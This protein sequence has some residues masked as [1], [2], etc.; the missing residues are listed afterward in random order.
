MMRQQPRPPKPYR[1][2]LVSAPSSEPM[3]LWAT[4]ELD[5]AKRYVKLVLVQGVDPKAGWH[6]AIEGELFAVAQVRP[7]GVLICEK[8]HGE[9]A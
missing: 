9:H 7:D 2:V 6:V 4:V 1:R 3:S 8:P 5:E